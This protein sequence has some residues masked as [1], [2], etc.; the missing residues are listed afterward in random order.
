VHKCAKIRHL[1]IGASL[2]FG[3]AKDVFGNENYVPFGDAQLFIE[4]Y[5]SSLALYYN[6]ETGFSLIAVSSAEMIFF[7][8]MI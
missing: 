8:D 5:I 2:P 4:V 1:Y 6:A 7:K 3:I